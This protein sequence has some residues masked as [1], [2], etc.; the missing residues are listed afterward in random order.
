MS[1]IAARLVKL[2]ITLPT[3]PAAKG[4]YLPYTQ[5]GNLVFTAGQI[6][7]ADGEIAFTGKCA[8][9]ADVARGRDAARLCG[10]NILAAVSAACG[11]D[12][13]RVVR[14]VKVTGFVA[15]AP[16]FVQQPSVINGCSDLMAEVF[17]EAG[18]HARSAVGVAVLPLD[19]LVECEAIVEIADDSESAKR[20]RVD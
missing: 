10:I 4:N 9:D 3:V 8:A 19:S 17:G 14:V 5:T 13:S 2:G 12:L 7:I 1:T 20:A 16:E 15:S 11:G 6:P 18:R